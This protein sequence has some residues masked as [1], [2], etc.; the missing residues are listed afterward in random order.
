MLE[1]P[2]KSTKIPD[3]PVF[4]G[5]RE[6]IEEQLIK[7]RN[8]L[9]ANKDYYSTKEVK[10]AYSETRIEGTAAK[11]IRPRIDPESL[12]AFAIVKELFDYLKNIY[13][14]SY[15]R[16]IVLAE[17]RTLKQS[18]RDFDCFQEDF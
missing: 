9:R 1:K 10:L 5:D 7:I 15:R 13:G 4:K 12:A 17:Y 14:D 8:K 2:Q 3:P 16:Q 6:E 18:N 11:Y